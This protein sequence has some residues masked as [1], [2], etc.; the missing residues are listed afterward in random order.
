MRQTSTKRAKKLREAAP[1][2]QA[3]LAANPICEFGMFTRGS[4]ELAAGG[5]GRSEHAHEI[6]TRARGGAIDDPENLKALCG[7][8]HDWVHMH[9]AW[10]EAHGFLKSAGGAE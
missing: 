2:R 1:V 10:S 7:S 6:L 5:Y 4:A 3:Y 8:C 9:P